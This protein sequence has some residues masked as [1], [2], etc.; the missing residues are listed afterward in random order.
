MTGVQTCALPISSHDVDEL[1]E[2][3]VRIVNKFRADHCIGAVGLAIAGFLDPDCE[4]VRFAPHLP[5]RDRH[6]RAE[7][8]AALGRNRNGDI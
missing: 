1:Q 2:G 5:W 8:Q 7:L 6:A 4:I 3:I